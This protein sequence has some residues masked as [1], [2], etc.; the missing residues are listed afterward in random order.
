MTHQ[1]RNQL[2]GA[3]WIAMLCAAFMMVLAFAS[4][5]AAFAQQADAIVANPDGGKVVNM[6]E[7]AG[8]QQVMLQVRFAE[9]SRSATHALG[10]NGAYADGSFIGANNIAGLNPL[11]AFT[12]GSVGN[13]PPNAG[14]NI[15]EQSINPS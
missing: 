3:V 8:G 4:P 1:N 6:L 5:R 15:R 9:I 7:V 13:T 12:P 10:I 14:A 2:R 11:T